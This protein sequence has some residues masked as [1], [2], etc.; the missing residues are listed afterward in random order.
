MKF[1]F[2]HPVLTYAFAALLGFYSSVY[3]TP[4]ITIPFLLFLFLDTKR[5]LLSALVFL[6][7]LSYGSTLHQIPDIPTEGINGT[8]LFTPSTLSSR[9]SNFGQQWIYQG[10][11][12][13]FS[14]NPTSTLPITLRFSKKKG[15]DHPPSN[16]TYQIKGTLKKGYGSH[17]TFIASKT[18]PWTPVLNTW[19]LSE[20]RYQ[21]KQRVKKYILKY[22]TNTRTAEFLSGILTGD[23]EDSL[24]RQEFG[25][26][27]LQHIMAISGFHF[28]IITASLLV[29]LRLF[30]PQKLALSLLMFFLCTYFVF[31]G[32]GPSILRAW[33]MSLVV[34]IGYLTEK[35]PVSLNSLGFALLL[36]LII[37]PRMTLSLGFAFSFAITVSILLFFPITKQLLEYLFPTRG[38]H[39]VKKMTLLDQ[40]S[41]LIISL[42]KGVIALALAVNITAIP[43]TLYYFGK[44][45]LLSLA[46]NL[47]IPFIVS[48]VM[49]LFILGL[50][51]PFLH[52]INEALTH[53]MLNLIYNLPMN[54]HTS[55]RFSLPFAVLI[56]YLTLLLFIGIYLWQRADKT[57]RLSPI[58]I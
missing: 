21:S 19:N 38:F 7:A 1:S 23:F 18:D 41:Y 52:P 14:P 10:S 46:Y 57:R 31:L 8:L 55:F 4:W 9:Q 2:K 45:P 22:Y 32:C 11:G 53:F 16:Q 33:A 26:V 43:M 17:Y 20:W 44:F 39:S 27:G 40:H 37:D 35:V 50:I 3:T 54:L 34:I 24:M 12:R 15:V 42:A 51:F 29:L 25:K 30:L 6:C 47:I 5:T 28:A 49:F 56:C 48:L 36:I 58:F 13:L